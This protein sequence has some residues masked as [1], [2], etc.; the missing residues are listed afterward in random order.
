MRLAK[1]VDSVINNSGVIEANSVG[2][3]NGM[4]VLEAATAATKPAGAPTQKV[5]VSGRISAAGKRKGTTGGTIVITG[6]NIQLSGATIN[7][8][9][10]SGRRRGAH[11]RRYGRR[12]SET[13]S[14]PI[15]GASLE[16]FAV[17][18]ATTV[19]VDAATVIN[20]SATNAGNGGKVI[21]WSNEATTFYGTDLRAGRTAAG[22][23]GFVETS[24]HQLSFN[25]AV[26]TDAPNGVNGT[27]LLDPLN[28][29]I[30]TSAGSE[31]IT[32][33]SIESALASGDV[34]VTT[35]GTTG[36]EAG[37]ITVAASL[38]WANANTLTLNS[39]HDITINN[40]VTIANTGA[41]NLALRA[42]A[43]ARESARSISSAR[44]RLISRRARERFRSSITHPTIRRVASSTRRA[45]PAQSITLPMCLPMG[46]VTIS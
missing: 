43:T 11:R 42:D 12:Q 5:K 10:R 35:V 31:V 36:S 21:V 6:E 44:G 39:Y 27:L 7:A 25:G 26:N 14:C 2:T 29:T 22:N 17:P 8:S 30:A 23:G 19:S 16:P 24:G 32:V 3:Q 9:G 34:I 33:S 1:V 15:A 13:A 37:D 38:S 45:I 18:T 40:G 41:G 46:H 4:I 28:A 20:A